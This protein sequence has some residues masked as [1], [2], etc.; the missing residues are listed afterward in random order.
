MCFV[1][2]AVYCNIFVRT[3]LVNKEEIGTTVAKAIRTG[4][5]SDLDSRQTLTFNI[6]IKK[7]LP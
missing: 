1:P 2:S 4:S 6:P 3:T 7:C 5:L